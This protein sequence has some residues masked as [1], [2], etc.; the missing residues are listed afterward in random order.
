MTTRTDHLPEPPPLW[1]IEFRI[2]DLTSRQTGIE[3]EQVKPESRLLEDLQIDSLDLVELI[4]A[5]EEE[6]A[7]TIPDDAGKDVFVNDSP[8][9]ADLAHI[10]RSRGGTGTPA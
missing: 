4:L 3:R 7:V 8:T 2:A 9:I 1:E 10:V 5:I 6:F